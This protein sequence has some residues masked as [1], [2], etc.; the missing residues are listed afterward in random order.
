MGKRASAVRHAAAARTGDSNHKQQA[1]RTQSGAGLL[2]PQNPRL[3]TYFLQQATPPNLPQTGTTWAPSIQMSGLWRPSHS[4]YHIPLY[5]LS[6]FK[7]LHGFLV[8]MLCKSSNKVSSEMLGNLL[9]V[10]PIKAKTKLHTSNIQWQRI[11][12][13]TPE[14]KRGDILRKYWPKQEQNPAGLSPN[15]VPPYLMSN[16][17]LGSALPLCRLSLFWAGSTPGMQ[18]SLVDIPWLGCL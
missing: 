12:I 18:L 16:G 10:I 2:K 14:G 7:S 15:P 8:S 6:N 17:L 1:E 9:I 3:V 4:K 5:D 13:T 11:Y